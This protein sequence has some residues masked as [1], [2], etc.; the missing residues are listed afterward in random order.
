MLSGLF[1]LSIFT[2]RIPLQTMNQNFRH[3]LFLAALLSPPPLQ[4]DIS[5]QSLAAPSGQ[6]DAEH[7]FQLVS[8]DHSGLTHINRMDVDHPMSY[9]YHSGMTCGGVAVGDFDGDGQ[10][11]IFF[12]G[13]TGPNLLY[14]QKGDLQFENATASASTQL[15]GGGAWAAGATT[16]DINGDGRLDIY[17]CN[18]MVPNQLFL[19]TGQGPN[20]ERVTFRECAKEAGI[21]I[22]DCSHSAAFADYDGDGLLDLYLLTNRIEDPDGTL[23]EMPII[24]ESLS[25]NA[26]PKLQPGKEKYYRAWRYDSENWGVEAAGTPDFL[27]R[28]KATSP[29]GT[30]S[31]ENT[32]EQAGIYGYGD[33][34]SVTWWDPDSDGDPDIY[35]G[36]DF[37]EPDRW[38]ENNGDGTFTNVL[39]DRVSHTPWFSMGADF[40]DVNGDG[41]LDLLVADMSAT[42]H[43]KSKT[44]MGIM[45][46][47]S[48]NRSFHDTPPQYMRNALYLS[49]GTSRY[50]EAAKLFGVSSTDWTWAIKFADYDLDGWQDVYFTNGI[51]RHMNDS[52]ISLTQDMLIGKHMFDFW[53]KGEMRREL[54]RA[55]RNDHGKKFSEASQDWGLDH[56]GVSYASA[57]ADLDGDG[58][59]DLITVNLEEPDRIYR[60]DAQSKN[61]ISIELRDP[62]GNTKALNATVRL[63]TAA[64]TQVRHLSPATGYLS[65]NQA[66]LLFGLGEESEV[67]ELTVHWPHGGV[68]THNN[69]NAGQHYLITR[70]ASAE[71]PKIVSKTN[72]L[73]IEDKAISSIRHRDSGWKSDFAHKNQSLL[74]WSFSQL[75]PALA[76][77]DIDDDGDTDFFLGGSAGQLAQLRIN[78]GDGRFTT[79]WVNAFAKDKACEDAGAVFFDAD[80]DL[81]LD[82]F[83]VGGS[84]EFKPNSS[85]NCDRL[86]FN[87]GKGTFIPA[88]E[89][90]LPPDTLIGSAVCA[91][92]FDRD[93]DTDLFVGTR[94]KAWSY[95]LSEPSRF[96]QNQGDGKFIDAS[97]LI[98][99]S[100][101]PALITSALAV[102]L[103]Q[104]GWI[105]LLTTSEWGTVRWYKN[106]DG[107][108]AE[109]DAGFA[110]VTGFWNSLTVADVDHDGDLDLIAGN[111]GLNTKYK[112]P[113]PDK[114]HLAYYGDFDGTG[115]NLVEVKREKDTL[116]PERGRSCS[117]NAMPFIA[118]KFDTFK[119]FALAELTDIYSDDKLAQARKFSITEF[120]TGIFLQVK[121]TFTFKP[122]PHLAQISPTFGIQAADLNGDGLT[123]LALSGNFIWGPQLETGA[124]DGGTG[125]LLIGDGR[126]DFS[127]LPADQSGILLPGDHRALIQLD[128]NGDH[129]PDLLSAA[130]NGQLRGLTRQEGNWLSVR[131][132]GPA[133]G[134]T[135]TFRQDDLPAQMIPLSSGGGYWSQNDQV[136]WF[137]LRSLAKG[138]ITVTWPDGSHTEHPWDG[139]T[140]S[141]T[142]SQQ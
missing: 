30:P 45:G 25:D 80:G 14:L 36:N 47:T 99:S 122:L 44:T 15:D 118:K 85:E 142:L 128:L 106:N 63:K 134:A 27:F 120:Q 93:G 94:L 19:N 26:L 79:K 109:K 125:L 50:N 124:F 87:D 5:S 104:D 32:T 42:S 102:D 123:D 60:N 95:P 113:Y 105:D 86:Y 37:S 53:K 59:P 71:Q 7:L 29:D 8:P 96:L 137:G 141:L 82:L 121:G 20:G 130:N 91:A 139:T 40:G 116:Y 68:Q 3:I 90:H 84:N 73:F 33:G 49:N 110:S 52:D 78:Q 136:A 56:E 16:A 51:S 43:F 6:A 13:S 41:E 117:S 127:P 115:A 12:A 77:A 89:G 23:A 61:R 138:T 88:P 72:P 100:G 107:T 81:D 1:P 101:E 69:L 98:P 28:Q 9:L 131:L 65:T 57:L 11:D 140:K 62:N 34:L 92:D 70:E 74:P 67:T 75:G 97:K 108:F 112:K 119:S 64:G 132:T 31:F 4:A 126:G 18:Y 58:D 54:N 83:V 111:I 55:Y 76:S 2:Q 66:T 48:L 129:R 114:P 35:I 17:V 38:Y 133:L 22:I 24:K 135:V 39:R 21:D 10:P 103:D 46:G